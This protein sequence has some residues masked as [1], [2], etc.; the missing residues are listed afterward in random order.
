MEGPGPGTRVLVVDDEPHVAEV[1]RDFLEEEGYEVAVALD[2]PT[3]LETFVGFRPHLVL[4]DIMMPRMDGFEVC[5]RI[6]QMSP[7]PIIFLTARGEE[8]YRVAGLNLG[9][10]YYLTKPLSLRE[11]SAVVRT[12]LRRAPPQD[13]REPL[14]LYEDPVLRVDFA[15]REVW[16]RG[17]PVSLTPVEFRLLAYLV[18]HAGTA[19]S[20]DRIREDVWGHEAY[21]NDVVKWYIS[22]L[23]HKLGDDPSHPTLIR[24]V[25]GFGYRYDPPTG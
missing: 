14:T 15:R 21:S 19:L 24:T 1:L 23:R 12:V 7:V 25:R 4:L 6:R 20:Q 9:A 13:Q 16:I 3:A 5:R 10:D 11:L 8:E 2:G 22:Q 18:R 17:E